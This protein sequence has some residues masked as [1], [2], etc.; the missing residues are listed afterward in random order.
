MSRTELAAAA[1]VSE[2]TLKAY[3]SGVRHPRRPYLVAILDAL[4]LERGV[5]NDILAS[6]GFVPDGL[7]LVPGEPRGTFNHEEAA[8]LVQTVKWPAFVVDEY[9]T[10]LGANDVA[11]RLWQVDLR[12]EF[13]D[14]LDRNILSVASNAR[15]ADR[16]VNWTEIIEVIVA[17]F[18]RKEWGA[19]ERLDAPS[20]AFGA[21]LERFLGG[22]PAYVGKLAEIWQR[23]PSSAW[24]AK[25][26]WHYPVVWDD[27]RVG[28]LRFEC[29][30]TVASHADSTNFNDWIPADAPTWLA[31]DQLAVR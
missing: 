29:M 23:T 30:V 2:A 14:P 10:V 3:E 26:R 8:A 24:D 1:H 18:K 25:M 7:S 15:F 5:R 28:R 16:C 20:P 17:I 13:S 6:A 11:Q 31:L 21:V 22:E 4:K 19:P 9:L 12:E 27:P